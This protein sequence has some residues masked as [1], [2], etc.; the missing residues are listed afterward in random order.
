MMV[1]VRQACLVPRFLIVCDQGDRAMKRSSRYLLLATISVFLFYW[2]V[3]D[4][5][6]NALDDSQID[7][8][9]TTVP[10]TPK[11]TIIA[12]WSILGPDPNYLPYFFQSVEA[13][14]Q[15]DLLFVQVDKHDLGCSSYSSA[16][17]VQ[18][19]CLTED[20]YYRFHVEFLCKRWK[21]SDD[22]RRIFFD[23]IKRNGRTDHNNSFFRILRAGVFASFID[24]ATTIWGWCDVD[25]F[26]GNFTRTFPWDIA[27]D[28]DV[29]AASVQPEF[30]NHRMLYTRGHM[31]FI[32]NSPEVL[33][34]LHSFPKFSS[35]SA[36]LSLPATLTDAEESELSH[37]IF[38]DEP[39]FTFL[40]FEGML[41]SYDTVLLSSR[42]VFY[43]SLQKRD[44]QDPNRRGRIAAL[45][46]T[47]D[48]AIIR[49]TFSQEGIE[50]EAHVYHDGWSF[51]GEVWFDR[52]HVT[53]VETGWLEPGK[54]EQKAYFMRREPYGPITQRLEPRDRYLSR[55]GELVVDECLY[56][57]WQ[58]EKHHP[59]F[60][61]IPSALGPAEI[62]VELKNA[63]AD[64]W[65]E[66]GDIIYS[67]GL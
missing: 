61:R 67:T 63:Q 49:P 41:N 38:S 56:K 55:D 51:P 19:L 13:N 33:D 50:E 64:I 22:E 53:F 26:W 31:A 8:R 48:R 15:V 27:H 47:T 14:D 12:V 46:R 40:A 62:F 58:T 54:R 7:T 36:Y 52:K 45:A 4:K 10:K 21:C 43:T 16:P 44:L 5:S 24:P 25:E 32:R 59:W 29:L 42:G 37:Y 30:A 65:N 2:F 60:R 20:Q 17:N 66:N 23:T 1:G 18:E 9:P 28:F 57:H 11:I 6:N 35:L 34:K 3:R 39:S